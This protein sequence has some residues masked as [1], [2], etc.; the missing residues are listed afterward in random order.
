MGIRGGLYLNDRTVLIRETVIRTHSNGTSAVSFSSG[1][2]YVFVGDGPLSSYYTQGNC[3]SFRQSIGIAGHQGGYWSTSANVTC[4][5]NNLV[6]TPFELHQLTDCTGVQF[7]V[8]TADAS[9]PSPN[10]YDYGLYQVTRGDNLRL[11]RTT[12][13][14]T[15]TTG[16]T[17]K[18]NAW[19]GG[20][21]MLGAGQYY[22]GLGSN[23]ATLVVKG[24]SSLHVG[25]SSLGNDSTMRPLSFCNIALS[26]GWTALPSS[27]DM[28]AVTMNASSN[29]P[30]AGIY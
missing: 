12:G 11:L 6:L 24:N 4:S 9:S 10:F 25:R 18:R 14:M 19:S 1:T 5:T 26:G 20:N 8:E 16:T 21:I 7:R 30:M 27:V 17:H 23:A 3:V 13:H 22:L 2:K 28:T 15:C 29:F